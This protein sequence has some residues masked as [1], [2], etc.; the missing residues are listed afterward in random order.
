ML[1][2]EKVLAMFQNQIQFHFTLQCFLH[3]PL[4]DIGLIFPKLRQYQ[5][6]RKSVG[7][8]ILQ[9]VNTNY[10]P[11]KPAPISYADFVLY[12][13]IVF[14]LFSFINISYKGCN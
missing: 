12:R 8:H 6:Q 4:I 10:I 2:L 7:A 1:F 3:F 13:R 9:L 11:N 5:Q 14:F